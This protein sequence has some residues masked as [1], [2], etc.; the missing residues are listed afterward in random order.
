MHDTCPAHL[1]RFDLI[2]HIIFHEEYIS[3]RSSSSFLQPPV[4]SMS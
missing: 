4:T 3:W 1:I 2:M